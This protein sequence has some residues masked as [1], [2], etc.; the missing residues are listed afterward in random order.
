MKCFFLKS[1]FIRRA[2]ALLFELHE[3]TIYRFVKFKY[4]S[5]SFNIERAFEEKKHKKGPKNHPNTKDVK[6]NPLL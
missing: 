1:S 2:R 5:F 3:G 4:E 6:T